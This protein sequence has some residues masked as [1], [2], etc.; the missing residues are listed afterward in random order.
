LWFSHELQKAKNEAHN[1]LAPA[2][3]KKHMDKTTGYD[4]FSQVKKKSKERGT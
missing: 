2:L 4:F 3:V 1:Q